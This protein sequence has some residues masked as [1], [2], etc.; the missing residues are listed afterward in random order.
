MNRSVR[1]DH[2]DRSRYDDLDFPTFRAE[3]EALLRL[4]P[5]TGAALWADLFA[6][7][8]LA[9]PDLVDPA[10]LDAGYAI[11]HLVLG[12]MLG[13]TELAHLRTWTVGDAFYSAMGCI[14]LRPTLEVVYDQALVTQRRRD[15]LE[16]ERTRLEDMDE[17]P[18][19]DA[20]A[21]VGAALEELLAQ[22]DRDTGQRRL[23][24]QCSMRRAASAVEDEDTRTRMWSAGADGFTRMPAEKRLALAKQMQGPRF[25]GMA[26]LFG[27]LE[28][29]RGLAQRDVVAGIPSV[30]G[31]VE[32]GRDLGRVLPSALLQFADPDREVLFLAD[33]AAGSLPLVELTGTDAVGRGGMIVCCDTSISMATTMRPKGTRD[34]RSKA[35]ALLLLHQAREQARPYHG[36]IFSDRYDRDHALAGEPQLLEFDF[37]S[38]YDPEEV[39]GFAAAFFG[40]YTSFTLPLDRAV[41]ILEAE[42]A[43]T[44]HTT[45][46]VVLITDGEV[47]VSATWIARYLER[48]H[49]IGGR[50]WGL[51]LAGAHR[52]PL[53][54]ICEGRVATFDDITAPNTDLRSVMAGLTG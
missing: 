40:G 43:A 41:A 22:E 3:G 36:I 49:R 24:L 17:E 25:D 34:L 32:F 47:E 45:S 26:D 12:S 5:D 30:P 2:W 8:D 35:M 16:A 33:Y 19:S 38:R 51:L 44:G 18:G 48:M 7:F 50:T 23:L 46:D 13:L 39:L 11:N 15:A 42:F 52:E 14:S 28:S 31:G 9:T 1:V 10:D 54:T 37:T 4:A 53:A 27:A 29:L 21:E 20:L 6:A